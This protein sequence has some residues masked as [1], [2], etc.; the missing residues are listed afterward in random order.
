MHQLTSPFRRRS[1][2]A[3]L[4]LI[5]SISLAPALSAQRKPKPPKEPRDVA[6]FRARVDEILSAPATAKGH[7]GLIVADASSGKILYEH[8]ADQYFAPASNTKLFTTALALAS[9]GPDYR[10]RTTV[11]T[12]GTLDAKGRL[13]GD[14]V[15]VGRG[16]PSLSNRR[17]PFDKE[18]QRDGPPEKFLAELA[19]AVVA[20]GLRQLD[21]DIV[22]DDS[23][24]AY[25]RFPSGWTVDDIEIG[26][27][28]CRERVYVLV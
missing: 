12:L 8:N 17:F 2:A 15:L 22:A 1:L 5:T 19:D 11:E 28:S 10:F 7:W 27:A 14:L 20:R 13:T 25:E 9:L 3:A 16:D 6:A 26:R 23:F 4:L 18:V 21:G 24:Y